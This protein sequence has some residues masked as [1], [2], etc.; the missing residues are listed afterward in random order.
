MELRWW[1]RSLS[2]RSQR[3]WPYYPRVQ[4]RVLGRIAVLDPTG[5]ALPIGGANPRLL[6][7]MLLANS[8]RNVPTDQLMDGLWHDALPKD[9]P[10]ALQ[11]LVWRLRSAIGCPAAIA[12]APEGYR[13]TRPRDLDAVRF[14]E[15][16][17]AARRVPSGTTDSLHAW[18]QALGWW[19]GL[20]FAE[21]SG[22]PFLSGPAAAL[23][24]LHAESLLAR[25]QTLL[26]LGR[27]GETLA[28]AEQLGATD[29]YAE[30]P[31]RL[32]MQALVDQ[33][34]QAEALKCFAAFR[35]LLAEDLGVEPSPGLHHLD[36]GIRRCVVVP[37][38]APSRIVR[39]VTLALPPD[40]F[41]GRESELVTLAQLLG[42]RRLVTVTGPGGVGKT[43]L[44]M[45]V[46]ERVAAQFSA[47]VWCADLAEV[48]LDEHVAGA[49]MGAL[50]ISE[51]IGATP[52]ERIV[53]MLAARDLLLVLD[54]CEHVLDGASELVRCV[55]ACADDVTVLATS[56]EALGMPGEQRLP[57]EPLPWGAESDDSSPAMEL[58]VERARWADPS[59][60]LDPVRSDVRRLCAAVDGLPLAIELVAARAAAQGPRG[61]AEELA[62]GEDVSGGRGRQPRHRSMNS[63]VEWSAALLG[64][65]EREAFER[66]SVF[67]GGFTTD[68]AAEVVG[69]GPAAR[70]AQCSLVVTRAGGASTRHRML[71]PVRAVAET[72]LRRHDRYADARARHASHFTAFAVAADV[73]CRGPQEQRWAAALE[74]ER[75]NLRAAN[76]WLRDHDAGDHAL[77][78]SSALYWH[79]YFG[80][81]PEIG[82]WAEACVD[83][84]G[85]AW[86]PHL[87]GACATAAVG[88][89]M[90]G[91]LVRSRE[92]A[93]KGVAVAH[94]PNEA[95]LAHAALGDVECFEGRCAISLHH[96]Q[97]AAALCAALGDRLGLTM[98]LAASA[99]ALAYAG[100][101][102]E[103]ARLADDLVAN[104][105][106][107]ANP[108]TVACA[109]YAAGEV[110]LDADPAAALP[111]LERSLTAAGEGANRFLTGAVG[112]SAISVEARSGDPRRA[113]S[114]YPAL[115]EHWERAGSWNPIW[116]TM[117]TLIETLARAGVDE[118]AAVLLGALRSSPTASA[119]VG[120][121]AVRIE[122]AAE[123][124]RRR[125]GSARLLALET[126]GAALGDPEAVAYALSALRALDT[127]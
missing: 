31:V 42:E 40:V 62:R 89:W 119:P 6:L 38:T 56:R 4:F 67:V 58:F 13:F 46:S 121:D 94:E 35:G 99:I 23:D 1:T 30:A 59:F 106:G 81:A 127:R 8:G 14:S 70:L 105:E 64:E 55:L 101:T 113:L 16:V 49:V 71:E 5:A 77:R 76:E 22:H 84:F 80:G 27:S 61:V 60:R 111:L 48:D 25:A 92:L 54:N 51:R 126:D 44:A 10:A 52:L 65:A 73:G 118:P 85:D 63:V 26:D 11:N 21:L 57:L 17:S 32:R 36:R 12:T 69:A 15:S 123:A 74:E 53:E 96:Y 104:V 110:R 41:V 102:D 115:L 37:P 125:L 19:D 117:R 88:A 18:E 24:R 50:R 97:R 107:D 75:G 29:P 87:A 120:Q 2:I 95:R 122:A 90:R 20:P 7:A 3:S 34:R 33:G 100:R 82:G 103:A 93:Q 116:V 114:R 43:R 47:G 45:T 112:L 124:L 91:D 9:P 109:F 83:R 86:S 68:S 79:C 66:L 28:A 108:S 78:M 72:M 39:P 98:S